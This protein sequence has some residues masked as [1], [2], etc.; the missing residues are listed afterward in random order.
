MIKK[1]LLAVLLV[2][3]LVA[4]LLVQ[5]PV[6]VSAMDYLIYDED[7]CDYIYS[8]GWCLA[9]HFEADT[10]ALVSSF[11]M[12]IGKWSSTTTGNL[13]GELYEVEWNAGESRWDVVEMLFADSTSHDL[14]DL[15]AYPNY[16]WRNFEAPTSPVL[17]EATKDYVIQV[18]CEDS[19]SGHIFKWDYEEPSIYADG[20]QVGGD[21]NHNG[22]FAEA[23]GGVRDVNFRIYGEWSAVPQVTTLAEEILSNNSVSLSGIVNSLGT[24]TQ[25]DCYIDLGS[26]EDEFDTFFI[27]TTS[28]RGLESKFGKTFYYVP[29][30]Q[31]FYYRAWI[32][33]NNSGIETY[34]DT[35]SF[36]ILSSEEY[37]VVD[38]RITQNNADSVK[39]DVLLETLG[40]CSDVDLDI[41]YS[42]TVEGLTSSPNLLEV[43]DGV[44][45]AGVYPYESVDD[46]TEG[47]TY[48]FRIEADDGDTIQAYSEIKS[49][50]RWDS[51]RSGI[52]N[53]INEFLDS[54]GVG[55]GDGG[56]TSM[57]WLWWLVAA[58]LLCAFWYFA[59][60]ADKYAIGVIGTAVT[61][62][63]CFM[64]GL[65]DQWLVVL[66]AIFAG[67]VLY[68]IFRGGK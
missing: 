10:N 64:V 48:Y 63:Y 20:E 28:E 36:S 7:E 25:V 23:A 27:G 57:E 24:D 45:E 59:Y 31:T 18:T 8:A 22:Y 50:T 44:S 13:I 66:L 1:V 51:S 52:E 5:T 11:S 6:N 56:F 34:G 65:L 14:E 29:I 58:C 60:R 2:M 67:F 4:S 41:Q 39:F 54:I 16:S 12:E 26:T 55:G 30:G 53:W 43:G 46:F 61:L 62:G 15:E 3:G 40:Q 21:G 37:P 32:E 68:W 47:Y 38:C 33:G 42:T 17:M 19:D 35:E 49:F 9:F